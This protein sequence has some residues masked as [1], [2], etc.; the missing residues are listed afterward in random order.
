MCLVDAHISLFSF[1]HVR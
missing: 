1:L